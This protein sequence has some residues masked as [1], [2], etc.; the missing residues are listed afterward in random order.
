MGLKPEYP[1]GAKPLDPDDAARL[2]PSHIVTQGQLNEWEFEN[3]ADGR[4][5]A[6]S[7][8]R[9]NALTAEFAR[10][11]HRRM[12]R[13]TWKW[14]G[15]FRTTE[16]NPG[17]DPASIAVELRKLFDDVSYQTEKKSLPLDEIAARF[18]HRL[19]QIHPFPNG[20]GRH[21]R[22]MTDILLKEN[23]GEPFDWGNTDLVA[24]SEVRDRY[25]SA[26]RAA[27]ARDP[28]QLFKFV[29]SGSKQ[30]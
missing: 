27:D 6:F 29:R 13:R 2:I 20:N 26:L 10:E 15:A 30:E 7:R 17:I 12:F 14:A 1:P 28:T 16:T 4:T 3:V 11:L 5:W 21:A 25:I 23:R 19:T 8:K 24:A 9:R 18:H 22:L